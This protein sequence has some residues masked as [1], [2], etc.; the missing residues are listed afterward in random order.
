MGYS[1]PRSLG[2]ASRSQAARAEPWFRG[3]MLTRAASSLDVTVCHKGEWGD[4][5][6]TYCVN[7][8]VNVNRAVPI[9]NFI[10][11]KPRSRVCMLTAYLGSKGDVDRPSIFAA[12]WRI[13]GS[14][15]TG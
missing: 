13:L 1:S 12:C 5:E 9:L 4:C 2:T 15:P 3:K 7:N 11:E 6:E 14:D 8:I 10:A